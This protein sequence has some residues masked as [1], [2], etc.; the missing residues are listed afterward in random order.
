[1]EKITAFV[2]I[3]HTKKPKNSLIII[4]LLAVISFVSIVWLISSYIK[5]SDI[6]QQMKNTRVKP[7]YTKMKFAISLL[8]ALQKDESKKNIFYSPHSVYRSLLL[9][10]YIAGGETEKELKNVLGLDWIE[11]KGDVEYVCNLERTIQSNRFQNQSNEL[12]SADKFYVSD[13]IKIR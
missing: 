2:R 1:M 5:H 11:N 7:Y 4:A 8:R 12:N 13:S 3:V 6:T 10:Y 9:A